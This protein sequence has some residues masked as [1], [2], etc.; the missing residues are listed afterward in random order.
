M[1]TEK[2]KIPFDA[3]YM[4]D[5]KQG[6][7][8]LVD[9]DG[10]PLQLVECDY[11]IGKGVFKF[12]RY[13]RGYA[14]ELI[15]DHPENH[16]LMLVDKKK[17][18]VGDKV[19]YKGNVYEITKLNRT[20]YDVRLVIPGGYGDRCLAIS[21]DAE[22]EMESYVEPECTDFEKDM[23]GCLAFHF[24]IDFHE[25]PYELMRKMFGDIYDV[26]RKEHRRREKDLENMLKK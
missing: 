17:F 24:G 12:L 2:I 22:D 26:C 6:R 4:E 1:K 25:I 14:T 23:R 21:Y 5:I 15:Y 16:V 7:I 20:M 3:W 9:G 10:E 13:N 11:T 8:E 19:V 18:D